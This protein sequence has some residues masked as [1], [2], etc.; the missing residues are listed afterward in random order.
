MLLPGSD[1]ADERSVTAASWLELVED[2]R[3]APS[4]HNTQ[5]WRLTPHSDREAE[6]YAPVQRL[7]PVE[8]PDGR[9]L[10]AGTGMFLETLDVAAA[11]RG[12]RLEYEPLYPDLGLDAEEPAL[13]ARLSLHP[14]AANGRLP[15][16]LLERRRTSRLPYDGRPAPDGAL[17]E[18]AAIA[19]GFGHRAS[20]SSDPELVRFVLDLNAFTVFDDLSEDDRRREIGE[21]TRRSDEEAARLGDGFSPS[22]LGFPPLLVRLFFEHHRLCEPRLVRALLTRIY[23]RSMRGTA[24]VGWIS[25]PWRTP[26]EWLDA[27]RML[28]RFW[29]ALTAHGLYLQPFGS[30]ITSPRAHAR[31]AERLAADEGDGE[32]WLLLRLGFGEEPPRSPRRP[33][34]EVVA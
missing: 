29:L 22:C 1:P 3:L 30:V 24:T 8:D 17:D 26:Q 13:V 31:L 18:L 32:I 19:E 23:L 12:L 25:G 6:L 11:A 2:A 15:V 20:F 16:E 28:M 33:A 4:P 34:A 9:F 21:W 7:L 5:P 14:S 10:T 27:G